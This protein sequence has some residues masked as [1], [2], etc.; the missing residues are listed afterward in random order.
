MKTMAMSE[1]IN[2]PTQISRSSKSFRSIC[3]FESYRT[4]IISELH[5]LFLFYI[6]HYLKLHIDKKN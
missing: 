1:Y 3:T 4:M 2:K 5:F 6:Y